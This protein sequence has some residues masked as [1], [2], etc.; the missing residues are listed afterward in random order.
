MAAISLKIKFRV[1][2]SRNHGAQYQLRL[3][4]YC[5]PGQRRIASN[6]LLFPTQFNSE[7]NPRSHSW[8]KYIY[9][10]SRHNPP[11][12]FASTMTLSYSQYKIESHLL[13]HSGG[14]EIQQIRQTSTEIREC[15]SHPGHLILLNQ[16]T[17]LCVIII[18]LTALAAAG[19]MRAQSV[20][21]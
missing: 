4:E 14:G 15:S 18:I 13:G 19:H 8:T 9:H 6:K 5:K 12:C 20:R 10:R 1:L 2:L 21:S 17:E 16:Q 11:V 7:F 3:N